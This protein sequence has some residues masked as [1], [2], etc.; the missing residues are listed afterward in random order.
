MNCFQLAI[1]SA[2]AFATSACTGPVFIQGQAIT[3]SG[4]LVLTEVTLTKPAPHSTQVDV[5]YT[6]GPNSAPNLHDR[7]SD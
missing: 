4:H 2:L 5:F 7:L 6:F 3:P 1:T